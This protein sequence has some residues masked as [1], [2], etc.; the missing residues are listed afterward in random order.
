MLS[1]LRTSLTA[2]LKAHQ[3]GYPLA[4]RADN[5]PLTVD[6]IKSVI[7]YGDAPVREV[8]DTLLDLARLTQ[9]LRDAEPMIDQYLR[10]HGIVTRLRRRA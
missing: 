5:A 2:T 1:D 8:A 9:E 6:E 7:E 10:E 3:V 4:G